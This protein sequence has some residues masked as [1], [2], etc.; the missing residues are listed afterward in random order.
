MTMSVGASVGAFDFF[1]HRDQRPGEGAS[2]DRTPLN[3]TAASSHSDRDRVGRSIERPLTEARRSS[4][5]AQHRD[6]TSASPTAHANRALAR[7]GSARD[8][9]PGGVNI[10]HRSAGVSRASRSSSDHG[11][12]GELE[13]PPPEYASIREYLI[14]HDEQPDEVRDVSEILGDPSNIVHDDRGISLV[15]WDPRERAPRGSYLYVLQQG[16]ESGLSQIHRYFCAERRLDILAEACVPIASIYSNAGSPVAVGYNE[17]G[18]PRET[19]ADDLDPT[20]FSRASDYIEANELLLDL[21]E[22]FDSLR[23]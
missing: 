3:T 6:W 15:A 23:S 18:L 8:V 2:L 13:E 9:G 19:A 20:L 11:E 1:D 21:Q 16:S 22:Y 5:D 4:D 12:E 17:E 10:G 14:D 7:H